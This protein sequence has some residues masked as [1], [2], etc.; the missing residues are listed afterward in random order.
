[1]LKANILGRTRIIL[2]A[3]GRTIIMMTAKGADQLYVEGIYV[4]A[5][6]M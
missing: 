3:I 2:K 1:M 6:Y 5:L 4:Y